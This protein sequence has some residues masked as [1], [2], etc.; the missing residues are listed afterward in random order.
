MTLNHGDETLTIIDE[1]GNEVECQVILTFDSPQPEKYPRSY[2][3]FHEMEAADEDGVVE[4]QALAFKENEDGDG[5]AL[6]PIET[7]EEW[8]MVEEV[9]GAF[10]EE[11]EHTELHVEE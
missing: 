2:V 11:D 8:D 3:V 7:E 1:N 5:G 6:L 4:I 10:I 9:I